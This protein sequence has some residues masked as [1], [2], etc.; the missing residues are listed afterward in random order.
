MTYFGLYPLNRIVFLIL[1]MSEPTLT[2]IFGAGATQDLETI[3]IQKSSLIGLSASSSN[4]PES[5]LCALLLVAKQFLSEEQ[6]NNNIDSS[7]FIT[8]GYSSF[9]TRD[10]VTFRT[11]SLG[12]FFSKAD[13]TNA[14]LN[15]NDY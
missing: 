9:I 15:P 2:Q 8:S 4:S 3:V 6:F 1:I 7:T 12:V 14:T 10:S 5:L 11:D 13:G